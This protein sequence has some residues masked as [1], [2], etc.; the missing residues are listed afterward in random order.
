MHIPNSVLG[1]GNVRTMRTRLL[2]LE[3]VVAIIVEEARLALRVQV[4]RLELALV[5]SGTST[6]AATDCAA[7]FCHSQVFIEIGAA[8]IW[9]RAI[10]ITTQC[11]ASE[12]DTRQVRD[13]TCL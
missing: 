6:S 8:N 2:F 13:L 1:A 12:E 3:H 5:V 11:K 4:E 7:L 10:K 9:R